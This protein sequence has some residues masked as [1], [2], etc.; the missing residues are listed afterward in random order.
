MQINSMNVGI[1]ALVNLVNRICLDFFRAEKIPCQFGTPKKFHVNL[2]LGLLVQIRAD[3]K[4]INGNT[5]DLIFS[6]SKTPP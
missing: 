6:V 4:N 5:T 1:F 3:L 2:A